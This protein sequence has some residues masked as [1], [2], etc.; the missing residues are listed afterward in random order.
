VETTD[1]AALTGRADRC[2]ARD[3]PGAGVMAVGGP[4]KI[5]EEV[6]RLCSYM[7]GLHVAFDKRTSAS[8]TD[9]ESCA[10]G[11]EAA[12]EALIGECVG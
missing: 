8:H 9:P 10:C 3:C 5:R 1:A 4:T 7:S 11:R 6:L 12:S 2:P